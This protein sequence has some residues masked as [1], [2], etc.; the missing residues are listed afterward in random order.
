[1]SFTIQGSNS[2]RTALPASGAAQPVSPLP[3]AEDDLYETL[4]SGA[5][6]EHV[7]ALQLLLT[8]SPLPQ[9]ED[10]LYETLRS[11]AEVGHPQIIQLLLTTSPLPQAEAV[12]VLDRA[13]QGAPQYA[14]RSRELPVMSE[15][16]ALLGESNGSAGR[17]NLAQEV[18]IAL[19]SI[20]APAEEQLLRRGWQIVNRSYTP[21]QS[22]FPDSD[23]NYY[24][25]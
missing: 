17:G 15:R 14:P 10:D 1:M 12:D 7:L 3:Q 18:N 25:S 8:T 11:A 9:A 19:Q 16:V 2:T 20:T 22:N 4:Q 24:D 6:V 5:E 13:V 21:P 23:G